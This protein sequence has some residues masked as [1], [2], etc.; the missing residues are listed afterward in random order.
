MEEKRITKAEMA[1]RLDTSR[2]QLDRLLDPFSTEARQGF[3]VGG[4]GLALSRPGLGEVPETEL[5]SAE[6][7]RGGRQVVGILGDVGLD[8]PGSGEEPPGVF[9]QPACPDVVRAL[10]KNARP[11]PP[12]T[13][14]TRGV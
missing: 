7:A 14:E 9:E 4:D 10:E 6:V 3:I 12:R 13:G 5:K 8:D 11:P 1:R 2:S